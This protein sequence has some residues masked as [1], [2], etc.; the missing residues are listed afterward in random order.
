M[1][2]LYAMMAFLL[3]AGVGANAQARDTVRPAPTTGKA[4]G[5]KKKMKEE[6]GLSKKQASQLKEINAEF[7]PKIKALRSDSTAGRKEKRQQ[8]MQLMQQ[9]EE[10]IKTILTPEQMDKYHEL[11]KEQLKNRRNNKGKEE[12]PETP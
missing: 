12:E 3:L 7:A 8:V 2:T 6:L 5:M 4:E 10:K 9:R 1:K 11:Q